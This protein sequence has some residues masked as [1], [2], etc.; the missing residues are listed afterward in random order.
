MVYE[1]EG[2]EGGDGKESAADSSPGN[3]VGLDFFNGP[4]LQALRSS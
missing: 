1:E 4:R 3:H 2:G